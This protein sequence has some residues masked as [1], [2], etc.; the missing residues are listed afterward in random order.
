MNLRRS[1]LF[2]VLPVVS[3]LAAAA[4]FPATVEW[5]QRVELGVPVSGTVSSVAARAGERVSAGTVLLELDEI[6]FRA[7][8][9]RSEAAVARAREE[10]RVAADD[11]KRAQ[12][13]FAREVLAAVEL[14]R[15]HSGAL[16]A[17][18][19][20]REAQ[21]EAELAR[22]ELAVS[23]IKAPFDAWVVSR[24]AE[25]GQSVVAGL[26]APVLLVVARADGYLAQARVSAQIARQVAVGASAGVVVG[27]VRYSGTVRGVGLEPVGG[28][29]QPMYAVEVSFS[30]ADQALRAGT[31]AQIVLP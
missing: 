6:P 22:H 18:A 23:K 11:Y 26:Q 3:G 21:A 24:R 2:A 10:S 1:L 29:D 16:R 28:G 13:L 9:E 14:D 5:A 19:T 8:V 25:A 20:L 4:E 7:R 17:A 31:P 15:A 12:E 27:S 30:G